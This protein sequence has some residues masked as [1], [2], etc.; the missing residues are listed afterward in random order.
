MFAWSVGLSRHALPLWA[1]K[2]AE[3]QLDSQGIPHLSSIQLIFD[4]SVFRSTV[5][6]SYSGLLPLC[7]LNPNP[8]MPF[9]SRNPGTIAYRG[10]IQSDIAKQSHCLS[11][12][13]TSKSKSRSEEWLDTRQVGALTAVASS[14]STAMH[15]SRPNAMIS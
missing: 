8:P 4:L 11:T 2:K 9:T 15:D 13:P 6:D 10:A 1:Q 14:S 12:S 5:V 3:N 7:C